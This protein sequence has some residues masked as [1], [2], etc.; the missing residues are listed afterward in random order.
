MRLPRGHEHAVDVAVPGKQLDHSFQGIVRGTDIELKL[1]LGRLILGGF[2]GGHA[3]LVEGETRIL[4][5]R[6]L[7][8]QRAPEPACFSRAK[9]TPF[10]GGAQPGARS[11]GP[12]T[13][14][15]RAR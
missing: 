1:R 9:A 7:C 6:Y 14:I 12:V 2:S 11:R 3:E 10:A 5:H 8:G 13:L 4:S 15:R